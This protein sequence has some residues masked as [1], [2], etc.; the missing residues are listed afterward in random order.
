MFKKSICKCCT[1]GLHAIFYIN[2]TKTIPQL[3]SIG[4]TP[5]ILFVYPTMYTIEKLIKC[6]FMWQFCFSSSINSFKVM[7]KNVPKYG[8]NI[9]ISVK[10]HETV[11]LIV[12]PPLDLSRL[13]KSIQSISN[14]LVVKMG[15]KS[16]TGASFTGAFL[17]ILYST[18]IFLKAGP[19][20]SL[21]CQP[22]TLVFTWVTCV[23]MDSPESNIFEMIRED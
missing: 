20:K 6:T 7:N 16:F 10:F 2:Y 1:L 13:R 14:G 5:D 3:Y 23:I 17:L 19:V 8:Q 22:H 12:Y 9:A 15:T 18:N 21:S 11:K 4:L